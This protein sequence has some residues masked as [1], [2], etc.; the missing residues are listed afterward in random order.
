M[1]RP[2]RLAVLLLLSNLLLVAG[3]ASGGAGA[4]REA[5]VAGVRS[6]HAEELAAHRGERVGRHDTVAAPAER[7]ELTKTIYG[8]YPYWMGDASREQLQRL[9]GVA[10]GSREELDG[11]LERLEEGLAVGDLRL[12]DVGRD[13]E[14]LPQPAEDDLEVELPH[15]AEDHLVRRLVRRQMERRI[16][17]HQLHQRLVDPLKQL[18]HHPSPLTDRRKHSP[19]EEITLNRMCYQ[20]L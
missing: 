4:G 3:A 12:S 14:L 15:P 2:I 19:E 9:R 16:L 20:V 13:P 18:D 1:S 8:W 11:Y 5:V 10:F 7:R 6:I 17:L